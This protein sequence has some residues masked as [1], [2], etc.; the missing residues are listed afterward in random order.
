MTREPQIKKPVSVYDLPPEF[1]SRVPV[2]MRYGSEGAICTVAG[3]DRAKLIYIPRD[4]FDAHRLRTVNEIKK[5]RP[6]QTEKPAAEVR[7]DLFTLD[8]FKLKYSEREMRA[9]ELEIKCPDGNDFLFRI[10][11]SVSERYARRGLRIPMSFLET[12][13][14]GSGINS[15]LRARDVIEAYNKS[16]ET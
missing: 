13:F 6:E 10:H 14:P 8:E 16:L 5:M 11:D 15:S 4:D 3:I 9:L 12:N 2:F 1:N 7:S